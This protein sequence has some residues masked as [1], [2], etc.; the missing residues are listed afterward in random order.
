MIWERSQRIYQTQL[1]GK[2]RII[3]PM[4]FL[5]SLVPLALLSAPPARVDGC[6]KTHRW[7]DRSWKWPSALN[8]AAELQSVRL[9]H[10]DSPSSLNCSVNLAVALSCLMY[11]SLESVLGV[12]RPTNRL[13]CPP[14]S[15]CSLSTRSDRPVMMIVAP[16][17]LSSAPLI[18]HHH[19]LFLNIPLHADIAECNFWKDFIFSLFLSNKN[20]QRRFLL[21]I[22]T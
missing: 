22:N 5:A 14:S 15:P 10:F 18:P 13:L 7:G 12:L 20:I 2:G 11:G 17:P 19:R 16:S 3:S 8:T 21:Q 9:S 6:I 1:W 4:S